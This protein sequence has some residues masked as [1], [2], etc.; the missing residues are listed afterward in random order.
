MALAVFLHTQLHTISKEEFYM[1]DERTKEL[2]G[3]RGVAVILVIA[4]HIFKRADYFTKHE[5]LHFVTSLSYIGW[6]GVDIFF[7]LSGFLITSILL[8]TKNKS[9]YFKTFYARR[10]LRIFPLYYV[11]LVVMLI[12]LPLLAP[13][14]NSNIPTALPFLFLYAQN[15]MGI[16]GIAGLPAY[17]SVTWSLAI[18]EQFYFIW[19][20]IVFY[21]RRESLIKIGIGIILT[22]I[23][24]RVLGVFFWN[25]AQQMASFFYFNTFTRFEELVFG[26]LLAVFFIDP[27]WKERIRLFSLP[28]FLISF[29]AFVGL[30]V[31]LFPA[32]IPYYSNLPLT[33]WSY[34]LIPLFSVSLIAILV[35]FPEKTL[36]RKLF[37][38]NVLT[39]F[40]KYSY[41]MYLLHMPV[42]LLLL[43]PLYN[44]GF[45][46]WKMYAFY[47]VLTY[48]ITALGSLLT[49]NLLE[50]H[51]LNLKKYFEY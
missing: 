39:F 37:R 20:A 18:E 2:D 31:Y 7:T 38:N 33:L 35:T 25:D 17:L 47:I 15:W 4:F 24:L 19:P 22:S 43:D 21:A 8:R 1:T 32:L 42:A 34:T 45:R 9:N 41:S 40:G 44:T 23:F 27:I 5:A 12:F 11:F 51:M 49:W 36:I 28:V 6:L 46:G 13:Y 30:C 29:S 50:K 3:L 26:A 14:Y 48:V 10:I 16:F